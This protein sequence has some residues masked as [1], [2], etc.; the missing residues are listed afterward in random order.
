ME[1]LKVIKMAWSDDLPALSLI[2]NNT[3]PGYYRCGDGFVKIE[4]WSGH[5]LM[6]SY[7]DEWNELY[8]FKRIGDVYYM[9]IAD[10]PSFPV[11]LH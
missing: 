3:P 6:T 2:T 10:Y 5:L 8:S 1:H 11:I 9:K 7:D 4:R